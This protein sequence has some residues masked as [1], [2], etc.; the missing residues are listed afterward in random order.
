MTK[1]TV[2]HIAAVAVI[3]LVGEPRRL[4]VEIKDDGLPIKAFRR[5]LCPPGG[6]WISEAARNDYGPRD[7]LAR[8][9]TEEFSLRNEPAST[10]ELRLLGDIPTGE[11]YRV[12]SLGVEPTE[13]DTR[14]FEELKCVIIQGCLSFGDFMVTVPKAVFDRADPQ[15]RREDMTYIV[16]YWVSVLQQ[17]H[18][19]KLAVLQ[20]K[21]GNLSNESITLITSLKEIAEV[22]M[23]WAYGHDKPLRQLFLDMGLL[24]AER[25]PLTDGTSADLIGPSLDSYADYLKRY[26]VLRRP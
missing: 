13:T 24:A 2:D 26:N 15:N 17:K 12:P 19:K 7:T 4:F 8:E 14:S 25:L 1:L 3:I 6:N 20:R 21:F 11:F 5:T 23:K 18:G 16:S 10:R 22:G 9:L